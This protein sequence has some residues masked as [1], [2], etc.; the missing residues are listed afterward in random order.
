MF[1]TSVLVYHSWP[2]T[3]VIVEISPFQSFARL[4]H[5]YAALPLPSNPSGR[6]RKTTETWGA[7]VSVWTEIRPAEIPAS[8]AVQRLA[9]PA[10]CA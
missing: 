9:T 6:R 7:A 5:P 10:I 8:M 4:C 3:V 2:S 1:R